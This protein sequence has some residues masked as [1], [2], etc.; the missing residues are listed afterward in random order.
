MIDYHEYEN[1][2][3]KLEFL[4]LAVEKMKN[5]RGNTNNKNPCSKHGDMRF[6]LLQCHGLVWFSHEHSW[7]HDRYLLL[8]S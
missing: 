2:K 3:L 6:E 8:R 5:V 1:L 7:K 4:V